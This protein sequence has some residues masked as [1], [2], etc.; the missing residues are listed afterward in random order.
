MAK[1]GVNVVDN[2][3]ENR[4]EAEVHGALATADYEIH[5]D[6]MLLTHTE[7]PA[8]FRGQGVGEALAFAAFDAA[9]ERGMKVVPRCEFMVAFAAAHPEYQDIVRE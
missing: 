1:P 7:V 3:S 2:P 9:R 8:Q 5:G 6:S 4:F